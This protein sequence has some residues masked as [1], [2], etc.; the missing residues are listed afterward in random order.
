[1]C[2][3]YNLKDLKGRFFLV[4][5]GETADKEGNSMIRKFEISNKDIQKEYFKKMDLSEL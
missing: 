2:T 3:F 1:M 4:K 5:C